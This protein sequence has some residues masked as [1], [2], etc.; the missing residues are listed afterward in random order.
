[1]AFRHLVR[2]ANSCHKEFIG[3]SLNGTGDKS[4]MTRWN[5]LKPEDNRD[6]HSVFRK[7][8]KMIFRLMIGRK[9]RSEGASRSGS[10]GQQ[11]SG[12]WTNI[13]FKPKHDCAS[14]DAENRK[15]L[16]I[17][18]RKPDAGKADVEIARGQH[19]KSGAVGA[20]NRTCSETGSHFFG[21]YKWATRSRTIFSI[22]SDPVLFDP[23]LFDPVLF[24]PVLFDPVLFDR[25]LEP[26]FPQ[27]LELVSS[28]RQQ[29][30]KHAAIS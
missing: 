21:R 17:L 27:A 15:P 14:D 6:E 12:D 2:L 23:V 11:S 7:E 19:P 20:V 26:Y 16:T 5:D 8:N 9:P 1:M 30:M 22:H 29:G 10:D 4:A 3:R 28:D 18:A 24:D 25:S 13:G